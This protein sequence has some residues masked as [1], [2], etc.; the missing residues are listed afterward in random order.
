M[1]ADNILYMIMAV[2]VQILT[3][4]LASTSVGTKAE[5]YTHSATPHTISRCMP[6]KK[7]T[8]VL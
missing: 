8:S 6:Y 5:K 7:L 1:T 2:L 3:V 4:K